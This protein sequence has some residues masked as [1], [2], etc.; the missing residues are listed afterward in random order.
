MAAQCLKNE[1][2][3]SPVVVWVRSEFAI[4][5]S[6]EPLGCSAAVVFFVGFSMSENDA[7]YRNSQIRLPGPVEMHTPRGG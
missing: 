4:L 6:I 5:I 1:E 3:L 7:L 2:V